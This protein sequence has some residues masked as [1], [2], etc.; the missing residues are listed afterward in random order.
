MKP[1]VFF[2]ASTQ[3][4]KHQQLDNDVIYNEA[5]IAEREED[6]E[7]I[8]RSVL[9]VKNIFSDLANLVDEQGEQVDLIDEQVDFLHI[10]FCV[11]CLLQTTRAH[12]NVH[13][14]IPL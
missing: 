10:H 1:L 5:Q 7:N 11:N 12:P 3:L 9:T 2:H 6:I 13:L 4:M 14:F 8:A